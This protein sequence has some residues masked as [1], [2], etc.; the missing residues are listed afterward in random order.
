MRTVSREQHEIQLAIMK[1]EPSSPY[2]FLSRGYTALSWLG[3]SPGITHRYVRSLGLTIGSAIISEL[4][5]NRL[6]SAV[7]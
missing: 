6:C 2:C 4:D 7:L 1:I 3:T 5:T